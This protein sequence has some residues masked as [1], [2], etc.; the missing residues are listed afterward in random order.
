[1]KKIIKWFKKLFNVD[2]PIHLT[3]PTE[4]IDFRLLTDTVWVPGRFSEGGVWY[5]APGFVSLITKE[6]NKK[7]VEYFK[8]LGYNEKEIEDKLK[9][10]E[11]ARIMYSKI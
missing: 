2:E 7:L 4:P 10:I 5:P 1:M 8:D 9:L 11:Q 6:E 3:T